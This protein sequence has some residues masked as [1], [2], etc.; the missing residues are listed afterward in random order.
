MSL[1]GLIDTI[2]KYREFSNVIE[3]INNLN[4]PCQV[5]GL[6]E[7]QKALVSFCLFSKLDK[8]VLLL[9]HNDIEAKKLYDDIKSLTPDCYYFPS[10]EMVLNI[11]VTSM[12]VKTERLNVIR[13]ILSGE[14]IIVV[15]TIDSIFYRM[16]P[17]ESLNVH[18]EIQVG[19]N[20]D[21]EFIS[22]KLIDF[23]Y[24]RVDVVEGK[25]Q[26]A[27]RGGIVDVFCPDYD[28]PVRI[29]FFGDEVDTIRSF[30]GITQRSIEKL[31]HI[32]IHPAREI[33]LDGESL[34]KGYE[35]IERD[36][37]ERLKSF[38]KK[39]RDEIENLK[40]RIRETL[41]KLSNFRYFDGIDSFIPYFFEKESSFLDYFEN[42]IIFLDESG[43]ISQRIF[44]SFEDFQEIYKTMLERG[45]ALPNQANC[46]I[47]PE[48]IISNLKSNNIVA[49]NMLPRIVEDFKPK[50]TVNFNSIS[51][52]STAGNIEFLIN[53]LKL[54][55]NRGFRILVLSQNEA[56]AQRLKNALKEEG[57][58]AVYK[59]DVDEL[60]ENVIVVSTGTLSR[61]MEFPDIKLSIISDSD[62]H[63]A[64]KPQKKLKDT[65]VKK[66]NVF[67]DLKVGDYV[68]HENHGIGLF[69]GIKELVIEGIKKDYLMIQY[70]G[71]DMLYV[72]VEQLDL[73]QK[74]I[75]ADEENP[76]INK[77]GGADWQ[78]TKKK[79]KESLKEMAEDLIKLYAER[80]KLLGHAFLPDTPW[81][82]QFEEDFPYQETPDQLRAIEEI[83]KDMESPKPMDRLL[84][85]DVGYGKTEVAMR[86]AFK[87]VMDGKQVAILVPTTLLAEQ[88]FN[89]FIQRFRG[90]P[91]NI[92]MLS[93]FRS[94]E[95]QK[96]TLKELASGNVDII[97]GT[98]KLLQKGI[99][100]KNLG[101]LIID[102]EQRF[103]V[104]HKEKIKALRKN[105][106]VLTLTAT[107]IPRTLHMSLIGVRD[108]SIIET[109]P[110]DRYPVQTYV[111][112]YNEQI[113][114]EAIVREI[115]RGGQ[116]FFVYNRVETM[117][118]MQIELSRLVPE[119]KIIMAH[120]QMDEEELEEAILN[121]ANGEGDVL[122]CTT[123]IETGID[124]PNVNTLIVYDA[125]RMGLSQLYQLRGRVGRS[126]RIAY[127][128]FTYRKDKVLT[129]VAEK[130][131]KAI[132]EFTEF[133]SGFKIAMR[134]L[135]IRG[136][137]SLFGTKQHGHLA[138]VGYDMYCKLLEEAVHE[139]KGDIKQETIDTQIELQINAYIPT[140][141]IED[142]K[143]KIEVYKKI[144]SIENQED[145]LDIVDELIDRFGDIPKPLD[146]L[147]EVAFIKS[148]A[149]TLKIASIK[150]FDKDVMLYFKDADLL[151]IDFIRELNLKFNN[152]ISFGSTKEPV[153]RVKINKQ[154]EILNILRDVL[155]HFACLQKN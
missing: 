147:I 31:N 39:K 117:K 19:M 119:V 15:S 81:Q 99:K 114:R 123:I 13:R 150:Q 16:P 78:K 22:S 98:H 82:K 154:S 103:G 124:M 45:N 97:I 34:K 113:I 80:S 24:E 139:L 77:L 128:Y 136:A 41:E 70:Q 132:K 102:E 36:F 75:G 21:S 50:S 84:C 42:P 141:Y 30:D 138:A 83:K 126:N 57:F 85:G 14:K 86:A 5:H 9:S 131:L 76:K 118:D 72:P 152:I 26:F 92:D 112:E 1:K 73:I 51:T 53:E 109:P 29:E 105:I 12:E 10:K 69:K 3:A 104:S 95:E 108:M 145:K 89:T 54:K 27:K 146:N 100:F 142:E 61:G 155:E 23:G 55:A 74:Y 66:I 38:P 153:L 116:V 88:H 67:T 59:E 148:I 46:F 137:G 149:K 8:Q 120:G 144:A 79:V 87:A 96:R 125:D 94:R 6:S 133:G 40:S 121:Y 56:R 48:I 44:A 43:R 47:L 90:F 11:D 33:L 62:L 101:L 122:L 37:E 63:I 20:I 7:S 4:T 115:S 111:L 71:S 65:K 93:R 18:F 25:G 127:A 135:E 110:E 130:R 32:S 107:P 49:F 91:V 60:K 28:E 151:K 68:V 106:D 64:K 129:E 52:T 35:G 140:E 17:K 134:D 58:N 143:L 2:S